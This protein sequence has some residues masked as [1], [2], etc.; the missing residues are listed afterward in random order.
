M[1]PENKIFLKTT[2]LSGISFAILMAGFEF[3]FEGIF[4][5]YKF[6]FHFLGFGI[7]MGL[8][9]RY[10]YKKLQKKEKKEE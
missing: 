10:N 5:I 2:F 3:W 8:M 1:K 4:N 6:L 9:A 7:C